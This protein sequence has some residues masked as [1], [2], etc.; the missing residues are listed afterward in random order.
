MAALRIYYVKKIYPIYTTKFCH[1]Y[2]NKSNTTQRLPHL[3]RDLSNTDKLQ[4][5]NKFLYGWN[6]QN[7]QNST[8]TKNTKVELNFC[9]P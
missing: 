3:V 9:T 5:Q 4:L 8:S 2:G 1:D 7:L 6:L